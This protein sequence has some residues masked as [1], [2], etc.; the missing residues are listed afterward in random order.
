MRKRVVKDVKGC[1]RS[2]GARNGIRAA[3][4]LVVAVATLAAAGPAIAQEQAPPGQGPPMSG[5]TLKRG[6]DG[7][8][9]KALQRALGIKADGTY[10]AKTARAVRRFQ[11]KQGLPVDGEVGPET[12]KALGLSLTEDSPTDAGDD[13][14]ANGKLTQLIS[15]TQTTPF[16]PSHEG[17]DISA[18]SGTSIAAAA[19]G[20][21]TKVESTAESGGYGNYTCIDHGDG[22]STCYAH[23]SEISVEKGAD[24]EAGEAIGTV[25]CTGNCTGPHLHFEVRRNGTPQDPRTF[26]GG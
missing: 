16:D 14:G 26:L 6:S 17:I 22:L 3:I 5:K 4:G 24:V 2:R 20:T 1:G 7:A 13:T 9:V 10:G 12:A 15:G 8:Q 11:R 25:G 18:P 19:A 21:V 23:L